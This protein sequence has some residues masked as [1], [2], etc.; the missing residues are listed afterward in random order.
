MKWWNPFSKRAARGL[1][2]VLDGATDR[3]WADPRDINDV[4]YTMT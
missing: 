1:R 4:D 3:A 2:R